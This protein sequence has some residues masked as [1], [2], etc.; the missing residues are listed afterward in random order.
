VGRDRD[1]V[2][3]D[4]RSFF[5]RSRHNPR[6]AAN[7]RS[8]SFPI[9]AAPVRRSLHRRSGSN[10]LEKTNVAAVEPVTENRHTVEAVTGEI[11]RASPPVLILWKPVGGAKGD[12]TD[13][14][15]TPAIRTARGIR[16]ASRRSACWSSIHLSPAVEAPERIVSCGGTL[17]SRNKSHPV[18]LTSIP[19]RSI[20]GKQGIASEQFKDRGG[21][22]PP[23]GARVAP[24]SKTTMPMS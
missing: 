23:V 13:R 7:H 21:F 1:G 20:G 8:C 6:D 9:N 3:G 10:G 4:R 14:V 5:R 11:D 22:R 15:F 18:V 16:T 24:S 2:S 19:T 12:S 17:S